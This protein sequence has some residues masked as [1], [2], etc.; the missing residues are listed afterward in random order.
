[1]A[2]TVGCKKLEKTKRGTKMEDNIV[3]VVL[4]A[5]GIPALVI[6]AV[7]VF[8]L[9]SGKISSGGEGGELDPNGRWKL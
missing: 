5:F 3:L 4:A 6:A 1:V 7:F 8:F 9:I 2:A